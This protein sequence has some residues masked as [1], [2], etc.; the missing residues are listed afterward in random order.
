M[1]LREYVLFAILIWGGI[2][3]LERSI[4][5]SFNQVGTILHEIIRNLKDIHQELDEIRDTIQR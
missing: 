2:Y 1:T 3:M 4:S 5:H